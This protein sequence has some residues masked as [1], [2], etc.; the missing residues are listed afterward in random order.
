[1]NIPIPRSRW[2]ENFPDVVI[3]G[4]LRT[5][6]KHPYLPMAKAGSAN[7]ALALVRDLLNGVAI[8][9]IAGLLQGRAPIIVPVTA[10]EVAGFN[11]IPDA[12]AQELSERLHL[13][14]SS[15]EIVQSNKVAHTRSNGW[16]RLVTPATFTGAVEAGADYLLVDDHVGFGGTFANLRGHIEA[17]GGH[18]L[19]L[20]ALTET[21][22]G[23]EIAVRSGTLSVLC[24][25]HG[26][27]LDHFWRAIFAHGLDCLTNIEAGYLCR[28]ESFDAIRNRL[29]EAAEQARRRGV[30]AIK[31]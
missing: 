17:N 3:H 23:K 11:A 18:V 24:S 28:V 21:G 7:A 26:S 20:T 15:G 9:R 13:P 1:M 10:L 16:H 27:D 25:K 14:L 6:D 4:D 8:E 12:M 30:S 5:R 29:A 19:A 2:P 31:V 22:G